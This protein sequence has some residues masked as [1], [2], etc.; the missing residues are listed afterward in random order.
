MEEHDE[1]KMKSS[2][3]FLGKKRGEHSNY[4]IINFVNKGILVSFM[5]ALL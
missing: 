3:E 2:N 4:L 1:V 5:S